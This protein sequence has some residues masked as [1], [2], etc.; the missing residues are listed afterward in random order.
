VI[1]KRGDNVMLDGSES[2]D[3]DGNISTY[4]WREGNITLS[5]QEHFSH[6]FYDEG[7]HRITLTV[8]D[9]QNATDSDE[10]IITINPCCEGCN[11]PDPTQTNPYN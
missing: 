2:Y 6:I 8:T 1:V 7:V 11:Y 5:T 4:E 9:D 10:K 3:V